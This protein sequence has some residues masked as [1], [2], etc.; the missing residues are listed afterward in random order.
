[1]ITLS[2]VLPVMLTF[3]VVELNCTGKV[4]T[5]SPIESSTMPTSSDLTFSP[6]PKTISFTDGTLKSVMFFAVPVSST[7]SLS[8]IK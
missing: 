4:S 2:V 7:V 5:F 3:D 1:M 8:E 6:G